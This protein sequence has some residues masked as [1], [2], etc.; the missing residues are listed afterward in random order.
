MMWYGG[1]WIWN[2]FA[3]GIMMIFGVAVFVIGIIF[4]FRWLSFRFHTGR[5]FSDE[6][7]QSLKVRYARGEITRDEYEKIK[8]ELGL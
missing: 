2:G 8:K 1:P 4:I 7:L 3:G 6:A 5:Y